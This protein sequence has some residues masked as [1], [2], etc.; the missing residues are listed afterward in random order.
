MGGNLTGFDEVG[1]DGEDGEGW[2]RS[3]E[4]EG[5]DESASYGELLRG[6]ERWAVRRWS[7]KWEKKERGRWD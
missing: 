7:P 5:D 1:V 4:R 6:R 3:C 2:R